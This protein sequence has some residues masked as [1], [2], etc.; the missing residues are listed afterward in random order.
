MSNDAV[1]AGMHDCFPTADVLSII[2]SLAQCPEDALKLLS[3]DRC[4]RSTL[5]AERARLL[6]R[7]RFE[8]AR[9]AVA[10]GVARKY[11]CAME[12]GGSVVFCFWRRSASAAPTKE[13]Y[14]VV[15]TPTNAYMW[16]IQGVH[17]L[18]A[19]VPSAVPSKKFCHVVGTSGME[20]VFDA[21][22]HETTSEASF[23]GGNF[24]LPNHVYAEWES[25]SNLNAIMQ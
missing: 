6:R 23:A 12:E 8:H 5:F 2:A 22:T 21:E 3:I 18:L 13:L 7:M 25:Y 20:I 17:H 15:L 10:P 11:A 19:H 4:T 1:A 9:K 14:R 24:Y 16:T